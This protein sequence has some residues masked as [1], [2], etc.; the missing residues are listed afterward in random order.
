MHADKH[1]SLCKLLLLFLIRVPKRIQSTQNRKLVIILHYI[2]KKFLQVLFCDA[3]QS[4]ILWGFSHGRCY[5]FLGNCFKFLSI[6]CILNKNIY[7]L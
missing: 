7:I 1:Q 6:T 4:D 3:K 2:K 5:L